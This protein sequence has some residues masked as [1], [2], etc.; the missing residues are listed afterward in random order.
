MTKTTF[1]LVPV[2]AGLLV[3]AGALHAETMLTD[4]KGMT[5][6]T[7]DKDKDGQSACYDDC[8]AKWPPYLGKEGDSMAEDWA[9]VS[10]TDGTMQWTYDGKPVYFFAGD[11]KAG[12]MAGE[13]MGGVWHVIKE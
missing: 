12:D 8:A 3:A 7:F 2:A 1:R 9:L 6:Y 5:L 10:R 11:A 13:G 4:A